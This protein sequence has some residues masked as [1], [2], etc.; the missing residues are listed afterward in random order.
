MTEPEPDEVGAIGLAERILTLLDQGRFTATYKYA[1]LLGL[2]DLCLEGTSNTGRPP[3]MATTWQLAEKLIELYWAHT[4]PYAPSSNVHVLRQNAGHA[5]SQAEIVAAIERFRNQSAPDAWAPL[6]RVKLE[7][8][9]AFNRLVAKV[10]WKLIEMPLPKLQRVGGCESRFLY[11]IAWSDDVRYEQ[12][13]QYQRDSNG[14]FDNRILFKPGV[15][16][17]LVR[18]NGLLRPLIHK[19]WTLK[20]AQ[21]NGLPEARLESFLFG[22]TRSATASVRGPLQEVQNGRCFYCEEPLGIALEKRPEVDHFI[23]WARYPDDGLANLVVAHEK[24]NRWKR[25]FL[26]ANAHVEKW[27]DRNRADQPGFKQLE[28]ISGQLRW[29]LRRDEIVGV[30]SA[31]YLSLPA[32]AELWRRGK[33]FEAVEPGRLRRVFLHDP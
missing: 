8:R 3:E 23:P 21:I 25:D 10:E 18:L 32:G 24:C 31:V 2:M 6:T 22:S 15:S 16:E 33:N 28:A 30:A 5:N 20:V 14:D 9:E 17:S 4:V 1:V 12:V 26:A 11:E 29:E 7:H 19:Q 27:L 13:R